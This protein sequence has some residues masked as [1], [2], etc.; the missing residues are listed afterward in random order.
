MNLCDTLTLVLPFAGDQMC[1][2]QK[3]KLSGVVLTIYCLQK[4]TNHAWY[5][6]HP[7]ILLIICNNIVKKTLSQNFPHTKMAR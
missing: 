7:N 1:N 4:V 6:I 3:L 2:A 5:H